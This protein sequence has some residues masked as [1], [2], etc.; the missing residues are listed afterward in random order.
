MFLAKGQDRS[1][2]S[3]LHFPCLKG[4]PSVDNYKNNL[5]AKLA[6]AVRALANSL[7]TLIRPQTMNLYKKSLTIILEAN[8]PIKHVFPSV[9]NFYHL[10]Y[11]ILNRI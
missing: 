9:S 8:P 10:L 5:V 4:P 7:F 2:A 11:R 3:L 6:A 1:V